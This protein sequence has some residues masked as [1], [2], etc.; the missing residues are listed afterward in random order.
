MRWALIN[1]PKIG[2]VFSMPSYIVHGIPSSL[3]VCD[4]NDLTVMVEQ[5]SEIL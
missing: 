3:Y 2:W 4:M 1:T 5:L